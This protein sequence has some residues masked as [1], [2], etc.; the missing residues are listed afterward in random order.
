V[1]SFTGGFYRVKFKMYRDD[2][3]PTN[4][5]KID[6]YYNTTA[7][8]VGG[9]LLGTIR[10]A[11]S[12]SPVEAVN[13]WYSY[14][15]NLPDNITGDGYVSFLATTQYGNNTFI[16]QVVIENIPSCIEPIAIVAS[17][18]TDTG[19]DLAWTEIGSAT[20]W[21]IEYGPVGFTPGTGT[22]VIANTN[23]STLSGLSPNT[24]YNF[25]VQSNCAPALS[26]QTGPITAATN[27]VAVSTFT[28]NFDAST[29][30]PACWKYL[31]S[32]F[33][34]FVNASIDSPSLPNVFILNG[35]T[36]N[37]LGLLVAPP[38][39]N[40]GAGTHR[41]KFKAKSTYSWGLGGIIEVGYLTNIL[42]ATS[43]VL[44]QS[45][46]TTSSM[47]FTEFAIELG[48]VPGANQLL[49]LRHSGTPSDSVDID[50]VVWEPIP[51]CGDVTSLATIYTTTN[52][53]QISWAGSGSETQW[54]YVYGA[55]TVTDPSTLT[56]SAILTANDD[57]ISG[58]TPATT[59]NFWVRS[60]CGAGVE[61]AWIGPVSFVT[62]CIPIQIPT[63]LEDFESTTGTNLPICWANQLISGMDNWETIA[64]QV[65][66]NINTTNSGL[67]IAY[68]NNADSEAL[69]F[70]LPLDFTAVSST[71]NTRVNVFLHRY[72]YASIDDKYVI[73][74]NTTPSPTGAVQ[75][76]EIFSK[77]TINPIVS[78]TGF[79]NYF[80]DIPVSFNGQG[81]VYIIIKGIS[82][83]FG[84]PLGVDDFKVE[85]TPT[86]AP[87]CA[88]NVTATINPT[89]GNFETNISW[90]A[91][92]GAEGYKLSIGLT[93]TADDILNNQDIGTNTY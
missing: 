35:N 73:Y 9:T 17:N 58:L 2:G 25:Y 32:Q 16:D 60:Y 69:L 71:T 33:N 15:F 37:G 4:A 86:T 75:I 54:Q 34:G 84:S 3:Y 93:A 5:D 67:R 27:C 14:N 10:R 72:Q 77:T 44:F 83:N 21:N 79:Y 39:N 57:I 7:T 38:V 63:V 45:F 92:A 1:I 20:S 31:G 40:A 48:T 64:P 91:P 85:F 61:G 53:A 41:L 59:Y 13:G 68:K 47:A 6:V 23:P 49:A 74:A 66:T 88:T 46:T 89:C 19:I 18:V 62:Q 78:D 11:I 50:D 65:F 82:V 76:S 29:N 30:I 70:S 24:S 81:Q 43:F 28:E 12:Y 36:F 90:Q 87:T 52:S 51:P 55:N 80:A 8:S 22:T 56:P 42:D 26:L